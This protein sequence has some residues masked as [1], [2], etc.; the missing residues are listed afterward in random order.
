MKKRLQILAKVT[1]VLAML[2]SMFPSI[3]GAIAAESV[4]SGNLVSSE[5]I[6]AGAKLEKWNWKTL[7]VMLKSI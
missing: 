3:H 4:P 1:T 6:T 2:L 7:Q 5:W